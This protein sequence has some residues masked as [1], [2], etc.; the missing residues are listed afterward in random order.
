MGLA[1]WLKWFKCQYCP[2]KSKY[3]AGHQ[4]L[5]PVIIDMW[6]AEIGRITVLGQPKQ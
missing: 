5:K 3:E 1:E 4:W 6:E 2:K